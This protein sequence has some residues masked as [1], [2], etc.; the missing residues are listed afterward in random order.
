MLDA[1][2]ASGQH[3]NTIVVFSSDHGDMQGAHGGMHE[4]WHTAYEEALHVPFVV[5]GPLIPGGPRELDIPTNHADLL[6]TLLGLAGI[7][8]GSALARLQQ[9]HCDARPLVGRDLSTAILSAD[10]EPAAEPVLFVTDDEISE[11]SERGM[12]PFQAHRP[13]ARVY[14]TVEQPNHI[15]TVIAE[16]DIQ[17]A[18]HLVKFSRYHDGRVLD[19]AGRAGRAPA[20]ARHGHRDRAGARRIRA[21]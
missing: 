20:G 3:E 4:K 18:P 9:D 11:G 16:V 8:P 2:R 7:D 5:A 12:S 1:L 19:R 15:E 17:G 21:L 6:P 10:P 13:P 14:A